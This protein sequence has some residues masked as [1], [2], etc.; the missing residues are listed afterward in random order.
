MPRSFITSLTLKYSPT[1]NSLYPQHQSWQLW[2]PTSNMTSAMISAL[3]RQPSALASFLGMHEQPTPNGQFGHISVMNSTLTPYSRTSQ[4]P[5]PSSKSLHNDT[6][7]A[8]FPPVVDR[9]G[10]AQW[11]L[12]YKVLPKR[13]LVWGPATHASTNMATSTFVYGGNFPATPNTIHL[14]TTSNQS[15]FQSSYILPMLPKP[16][17]IRCMPQ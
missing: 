3:R 17:T 8:T 7:W 12:P 13:S 14:P 1:F 2:H 4:I 10:L 15:Q 9:S 16:A 11:Q 6:R 5:Y